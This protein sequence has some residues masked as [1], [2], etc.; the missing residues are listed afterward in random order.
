MKKPFIIFISIILLTFIFLF[1]IEHFFRENIPVDNKIDSENKISI[2]EEPKEDSHF[3][4][5]VIGK[6]GKIL[7]Y[8]GTWSSKARKNF[9]SKK[10]LYL[11][12]RNKLCNLKM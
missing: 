12:M 8:G 7:V 4:M 5:S 2:V 11:N 6:S 3:S 9:Q 10:K 1:I